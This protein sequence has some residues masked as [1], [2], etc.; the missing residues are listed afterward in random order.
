MKEFRQRFSCLIAATAVAFAITSSGAAQAAPCGTGLNTTNFTF[1]GANADVCAGP[2]GGN[3]NSVTDF[4]NALNGVS[5]IGGGWDRF[6]T[7]DGAMS[8]DW[9]GFRFRFQNAAVVGPSPASG[10][11]WLTLTDLSPDTPPDYPISFD[12]LLAPKAGNQWAAY[13]FEDVEFTLDSTGAGTWLISF[14]NNPNDEPAGLSHMNFLLRDFHGSQCTVNCEPPT[15]EP[16][17]QSCVPGGNTVP[18]P[19]SLELLMVAMM[20]L[21]VARSRRI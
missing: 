4:N 14:N 6:L 16:C 5:G 3:P 18:E 8:V 11:F 21:T 7:S 15:E 19:G 20:C 10:N 12:L 1:R 9:N 2:I 13:L 17:R